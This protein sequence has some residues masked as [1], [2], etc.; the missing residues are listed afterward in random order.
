MEIPAIFSA[1]RDKTKN[2]SSPKLQNS[3]LFRSYGIICENNLNVCLC[4]L[5]KAEK[6]QIRHPRSHQCVARSAV[7]FAHGSAG[8][9]H[10]PALPEGSFLL[11]DVLT[12]TD[13]RF[14]NGSTAFRH[15]LSC[16]RLVRL[17]PDTWLGF[18]QTLPLCGNRMLPPC[19]DHLEKNDAISEPPV[20]IA[21]ISI[22]NMKPV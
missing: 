21:G 16:C 14:G 17:P 5:K 19:I 7:S 11:S 18:A 10:F 4:F 12:S 13:S 1:N 2:F 20:C 6:I 15:I 9:L 22:W 3:L 8:F